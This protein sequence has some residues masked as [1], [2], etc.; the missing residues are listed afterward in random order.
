MQLRRDSTRVRRRVLAELA[1][2]ILMQ[3]RTQHCR[4]PL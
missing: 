1:K 4:A 2:R 3:L